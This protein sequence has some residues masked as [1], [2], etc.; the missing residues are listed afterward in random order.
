ML[1]ACGGDFIPELSGLPREPAI[2]QHSAY[3]FPDLF[4]CWRLG[5]EID[6]NPGVRNPRVHLRL[7]LGL[8]GSDYR[9][10]VS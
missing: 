4:R 10:A 3:G 7:I 8:A 2:S 5:L 9:D 1:A 6:A